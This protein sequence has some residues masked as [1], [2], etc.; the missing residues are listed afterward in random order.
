VSSPAVTLVS[1]PGPPPAP[2][3]PSGWQLGAAPQLFPGEDLW[4]H[5]DGAADQYLGFGCTALTVTHY[6]RPGS[7]SEIT[8]E[9]Y[10]T[11]DSLGAFGLYMLE[12][13]GAGPYLPLGVE[14]Y[15]AGPDLGFFG[16]RHY[17]KVF[18]H[19][20]GEIESA[21]ARALAE[22]FAA[23]HMA[24]CGFPADLALFPRANLV[25]GGYGY[26]PAAALSLDGLDR[27]LFA[28]YHASERDV[29]IYVARREDA[30]SA[31]SAYATVRASLA[32]R[33]TTPLQPVETGGLA[34]ERGELK[35]RGRVW[36]LQRGAL[37]IVAA[38]TASD[39]TIGD[40]LG[41]LGGGLP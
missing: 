19:P 7:E 12:R 38:G 22:T 8:L 2:E 18:A 4:R 15:Q 21:A 26:A 40:L 28:R 41:S 24:G 17:V 20:G 3:A 9:V 13:P 33:S 36:L 35:Y 39:A 37:V 5:I 1:S 6:A 10:A 31:A 30:D 34:G 23:E 11:A 16:G 14:G 29:T 27:A 25:A 32:R